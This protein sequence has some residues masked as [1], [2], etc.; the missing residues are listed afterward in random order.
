MKS[1]RSEDPATGTFNEARGQRAPGWVEWAETMRR[2]V[3]PLPSNQ[4]AV[5]PSDGT[6]QC[7]ANTDTRCSG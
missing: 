1:Q 6:P 7:L 4:R 5:P 3:D 2:L